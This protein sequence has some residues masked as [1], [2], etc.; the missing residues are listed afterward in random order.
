MRPAVAIIGSDVDISGGLRVDWKPATHFGIAA[1]CNP[2]CFKLSH[3]VGD[4]TFTAKQTL[5]GPLLRIGLYF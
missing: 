3:T 5:H 1:G 4:R 2:L